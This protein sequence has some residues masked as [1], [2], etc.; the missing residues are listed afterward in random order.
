MPPR[1][2]EAEFRRDNEQAVVSVVAF[3]LSNYLSTV[4]VDPAAER[5]RL[6]RELETITKHIAGTEARLANEAFV[7]K[8]P[9]A[10]LAGAKKQLAD[11]QA[12]RAELERLLFAAEALPTDW[13]H[14][15]S[16]EDRHKLH[17]KFTEFALPAWSGKG[18][19]PSCF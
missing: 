17:A 9:P 14:L 18:R 7:S 10:V 12:K 5:T 1:E 11:Q 16:K 3:S 4:K 19:M 13:R 2:A 6:K 15:L 8:A